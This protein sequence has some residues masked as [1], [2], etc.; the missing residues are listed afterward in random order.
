M[1][2]EKNQLPIT[3]FNKYDWHPVKREYVEGYIE[4]D[5]QI[6]PT[7]KELSLKHGIPPAY[8]RRVASI[9]KWTIEKQ[10]YVTNY[11]H[12]IQ[13]EKIKYL[14]KKSAAFDDK[15]I[16]IAEEGVRKIENLL[17]NEIIDKNGVKIVIGIDGIECAAKTLEKFQKIGRLALGNSTDNVTKSIKAATESI[18]FTDGLNIIAKQIESNPELKRKLE[19]EFMDD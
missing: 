13:S 18:S 9:Q 16:K 5:K 14:A 1:F 8:L 2:I 10:N 19:L 11:E 12:A 15:C 3:I 6:W 4:N 7:M 17:C